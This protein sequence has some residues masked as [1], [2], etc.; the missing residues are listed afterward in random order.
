ML[1]TMLKANRGN[2]YSRQQQGP[3]LFFQTGAG[4][5][6]MKGISFLFF[7]QSIKASSSFMAH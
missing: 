5:V 3:F 7:K 2:S 1:L 4:G 6:S